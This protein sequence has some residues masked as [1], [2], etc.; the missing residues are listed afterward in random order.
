MSIDVEAA[1]RAHGPMVFRRCRGMLKDEEQATDAMH[2]VFVLL[3]RNHQR[4]DDAHPVS[5][6]YRMA[7]NVCLNQIRSKKRHLTHGDDLLEIIA[8]LDDPE[9]EV[10]RRHLL[11][12]IFGRTEA[13]T[14][15]MATL[16]HVDGLTLQEVADHVGMSVSGVRKRLA[17]LS[18]LAKDLEARHDG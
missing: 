1:Y 14:R 2:E 3:V 11:S 9:E 13:S 4:L 18:T 15:L 7:T 5:L 8:T 16:H 17:G 10:G 12:R 6:L